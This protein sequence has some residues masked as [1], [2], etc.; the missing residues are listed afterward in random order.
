MS[1]GQNI[2]RLRKEAGLSQEKLAKMLGKTRSAVSYYESDTII[3]RMGVIEEL[4]AIFNVSKTE[5][6]EPIPSF[7][8]L[9]ANETELVSIMRR[10]TPEGQRQMMIYA[11]GV[12]STYSKN[13]QVEKTA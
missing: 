11:R 12:D 8:K 2:K 6:I 13:N 9:T 4:A 5:I 10:I 3:P 7:G 1:I